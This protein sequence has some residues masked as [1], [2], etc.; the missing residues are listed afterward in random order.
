VRD[1]LKG[2]PAKE[3]GAERGSLSPALK[4]FGGGAGLLFER[5]LRRF[6]Q[7]LVG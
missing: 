2:A 7:A 3:A 6:G 1:N 4:T 5:V